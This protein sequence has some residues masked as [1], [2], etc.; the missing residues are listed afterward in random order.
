MG[1]PRQADEPPTR[2]PAPVPSAT[3]WASGMSY[4]PTA[5]SAGT[6]T[7]PSRS[8][9]VAPAASASISG[10]GSGA[11]RAMPFMSRNSARAAPDTRPSGCSGPSSQTWASSLLSC[12][13]S[14]AS[15]AASMASSSRV[16]VG[17]NGRSHGAPRTLGAI[18]TSPATRPGCA[19]A[20]SSATRPPIELPT[21]TAAPTPAASST[22]TASSTWEYRSGSY[23]VVPKPRRSYAIGRCVPP[24]SPASRC[25]Q[26]RS[27]T[28]GV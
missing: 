4:S 22:A 21:T 14:P 19:S 28:P 9:A 5:T 10:P 15:S 2:Q 16:T 3:W 6:V 23:V 13:R 7:S 20:S 17:G 24:I 25:Q 12:S 11:A 1:D 8:H 18:R 27:A 26:R